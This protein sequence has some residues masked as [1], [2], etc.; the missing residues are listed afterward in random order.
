MDLDKLGYCAFAEGPEA[1]WLTLFQH[2]RERTGCSREVGN[3]A[4]VDVGQA[5][6]GPDL[7]HCTRVSC[8]RWSRVFNWLL[9]AYSGG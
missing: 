5:Q 9:P 6:K 8:P 4:A 7:G 2:R 3:E 1:D